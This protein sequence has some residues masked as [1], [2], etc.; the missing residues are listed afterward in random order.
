MNLRQINFKQPKYIFPLV[1]A[2]PAACLIYFVSN[3]FGGPEETVPTDR[4]NMNLPEAKTGSDYDKLRSMENR[5]SKEGNLFSAVDGFGS[6]QQG[7]ESIEGD[8]YTEDEINRIIEEAERK[9]KGRENIAAMQ[10]N[11]AALSSRI[12]AGASYGAETSSGYGYEDDVNRRLEEIQLKSR[13]RMR[14]LLTDPDEDEKAR[15]E[16]N[17]IVRE[18][19]QRKTQEEA[20][21]EV[22]KASSL[23]HRNFNTVNTYA[24]ESSDSP[25][26]KAMID[27]TT[28]STE[29]TR[30]RFKLLDDVIIDD[31]KLLKGSY[32]YGTVSGFGTQRVMANITSVLVGSRFLK[33]NLSVYDIDGMEGFYVPASSFREFVQNAAAGVAGQQIQFNNNGNSGE[34]NPEMLALQALQN[35]YQAGSGAL[36]RNIKKNKAKIK[37][38]TIVYLINS[39]NVK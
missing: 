11:L 9:Q 15:A 10:R 14:D 22:I 3:M 6:G 18:E 12:A 7:K 36:S 38:N 23:Q 26:I 5:Y 33:V 21:S 30:L 20:P 24:G 2:V 16:A 34:I 1:I 8:E 25:L 35:I 4:I 17:R 27:K 19:M 39:N 32:L 28:K 13:Q 37:Y 29:G 31:V